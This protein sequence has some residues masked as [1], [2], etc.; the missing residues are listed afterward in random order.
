MY[1]TW[2]RPP[3]HSMRIS[4]RVYLKKQ[5]A[6]AKYC[7]E[8]ILFAQ[9][10]AQLR[11]QPLCLAMCILVHLYTPWFKLQKPWYLEISISASVTSGKTVSH[12]F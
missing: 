1:K 10:L 12:E 4:G 7:S 2:H 6:A 9:T 3:T 11:L 8:W 5:V